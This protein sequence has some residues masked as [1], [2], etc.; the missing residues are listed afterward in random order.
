MKIYVASSW[1]NEL[2]PSVVATLRAQ[3]H[4]VYDFRNPPEASGFGWRE[5]TDAPHPWS[6]AYTREVLAMPVCDRAFASDSGG[7]R[8][9]DGV[10]MLQPCGVSAAL[11]LG[12]A[13]GA[14]KRTCVLLSDYREPELMLKFA[15]RICVSMAEVIEFFAEAR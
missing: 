12:W 9:A 1:R 10:L 6:A 3:G 11:E 7:L 5:A 14:G 2:Q 15:D 13:C 8:W 4:E